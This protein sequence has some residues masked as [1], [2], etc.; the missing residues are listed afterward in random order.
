MNLHSLLKDKVN[1][2]IVNGQWRIPFFVLRSFPQVKHLAEQVTIPF[3]ETADKLIWK[4]SNN[5]ELSFKQ[6]F[7][8]KYGTGQNI[9]WA[10]SLWCP[11]IPP[12]KSLLVWRIMH[13]K[14][15]IDDKLL[16]RGVQ[17]PSICVRLVILHANPSFI[18][19]LSVLLL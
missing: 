2:F 8:F 14:I 11:E 9:K 5:G 10:K 6:A 15:P 18:Y 12:S 19:F 7:E 1:E 4:H 13:R 3:E 17:L 16:H